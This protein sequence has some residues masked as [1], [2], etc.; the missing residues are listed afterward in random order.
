MCVD[1]H[2]DGQMQLSAGKK[3]LIHTLTSLLVGLGSRTKAISW[4]KLLYHSQGP[5]PP[6]RGMLYI[7]IIQ[8]SVRSRLSVLSNDNSNKKKMEANSINTFKCSQILCN[9]S[10]SLAKAP[11]GID[12][13]ILPV[14]LAMTHLKL[15]LSPYCNKFLE[16]KISVTY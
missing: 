12:M 7:G 3:S 2:A 6:A 4:G 11:A 8:V 15:I 13:T 10:L 16:L 14:L 1:T 9:T 5:S